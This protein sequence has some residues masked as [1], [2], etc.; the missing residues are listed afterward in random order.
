MVRTGSLFI[1]YLRFLIQIRLRKCRGGQ[2][3]L[4]IGSSGTYHAGWIST[5]ESWLDI[6]N[7]SDWEKYFAPGEIDAIVAEHVFE[8]IEVSLIQQS[9]HNIYKYLR[10]GGY[11]RIAVPDGYHPSEKYIRQVMPGGTGPGAMDHKSLFTHTSLA[12]P[13]TQTGFELIFLE[14]FDINRKFHK[15]SWNPKD[16]LIH[17]SLEFDKRNLFGTN[18]YSSIIVDATKPKVT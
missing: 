4:I 2:L 7:S 18:N 15:H 1:G 6:S 8:H 5:E 12:A 11:V 17:R 9:L 13:L 14:Y 3:R 10:P 16:G